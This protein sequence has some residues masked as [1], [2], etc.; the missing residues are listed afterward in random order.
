[1][2]N[3]TIV[4]L[5][6]AVTYFYSLSKFFPAAGRKT[7]E[8]LVPGYNIWIWLKITK[9]PWWYIFLLIFPGVNV[10]VLMIMSVNLSTVFG[11]RSA[12][13]VFLSAFFPFIYLPYIA[14]KSPEYIGP[15][16]KSKREKI[17][18]REWRDAILFA[19]IAASLIRTYAIEAYTIPT[20]SMEKTLL[21]GDYLFVSKMAYGPKVP[22]TPLSFPFSHHSLPFTN[23]GV[24]SYLE[25]IKL[26]YFRL[27]GFGEVERNDVVV[28]NY[29]EGDTVDIEFQSN[30]SY[31]AMIREQA[32]QMQLRDEYMKKAIKTREEYLDLSKATIRSSREL[33]VRPVDKRENYIKRC[34][35]VPGDKLEVN[36]GIL[37][38]N[39]EIAYI[40]P[41][42]QYNFFVL[43][44]EFLNKN[45]MK[46][47]F[48]INFQDLRKIPENPGYIIPLTLDAYKEV[49]K[50]PVIKDVKP[51]INKKSFDDPTYRIFPNTPKYDWTEDFFGP[52]E[53]P[54]KGKSIELT[55]ENL[56]LY[57]RL[58]TIYEGNELRVEDGKILI[59]DEITK[60]YTP[61]MNY[62][63][64]MGDN[65]HNSADSR[66]WGFVPED[67]IV[68]RASFIWLSI[69]PEIGLFDGAIRWGRM[70][71]GIE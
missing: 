64:M 19:V 59:N 41:E 14:S 18:W 48:D 11:K 21:I 49:Q 47:K 63:W 67:H 37:Y 57:K 58:I 62:Y 52:I 68:G 39:D 15:I 9:K 34:V 70:F 25:W 13:D 53:I 71:S 8:A 31:Q 23:N 36:K 4:Y 65:R 26:P 29:P 40:P 45:T 7:W 17:W 35:A 28:F 42:F 44:E 56:P 3:N 54:Q 12:Q 30:K 16:D 61:K 38:I 1:M 5:L 22:M 32:Y 55:L 20:S 50:F 10:L 2:D 60:S 46:A 33:T 24:Q 6:I 43:T 51:F 66:F 69:D 27:P